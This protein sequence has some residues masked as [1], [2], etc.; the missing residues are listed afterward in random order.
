MRITPTR[1]KQ[2]VASCEYCRIMKQKQTFLSTV[3]DTSVKINE[4]NGLRVFMCLSKV[5]ILKRNPLTSHSSRLSRL[6][7]TTGKKL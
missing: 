1:L 7:I 3:P 6:N 5:K 4:N 2:P